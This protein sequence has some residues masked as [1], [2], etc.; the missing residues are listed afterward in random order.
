MLANMS[1]PCL[2]SPPVFKLQHTVRYDNLQHYLSGHVRFGGNS[3]IDP[4]KVS[5]LI[6]YNSLTSML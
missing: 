3:V 1:T 5:R 2:I 4:F 6:R